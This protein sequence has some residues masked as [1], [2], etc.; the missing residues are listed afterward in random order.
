MRTIGPYQVIQNIAQN[1]VCEVLEVEHPAHAEPLVLK[2]VKMTGSADRRLEREF[3]ALRRMEHPS[4]VRVFEQGHDI[5]GHRFV[6]MERLDGISAQQWVRDFGPPGSPARTDEAV[7]IISSLASALQA[8]HQAGII[9]RDIKSDNVMILRDGTV[10]LL[11]FGAARAAGL[12]EGITR[13]GEFIGTFDYASPEQITG[14][15]LDGR[16]D[17]YALGVLFYRLLTGRRPFDGDSRYK[18]ARMHL[19]HTPPTPHHLC[20]AVPAPLSEVVM[21]MLTKSPQH[22]PTALGVLELLENPPQ[23]TTRSPEALMVWQQGL[24]AAPRRLV[25][26]LAI[27][28]TPLRTDA[29]RHMT[30]LP[31]ADTV[32]A[33]TALQEG[34]WLEQGEEGWIFCDAQAPT[35]IGSGVQ[36]ARRYLLTQRLRE[37][38]P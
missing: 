31:I 6:T 17:V 38:K 33:L 20:R 4:V 22:R 25:Q 37:F 15:A 1:E 14:D 24:A 9:H 36:R 16:A 34:G 35:L 12:C 30:D 28:R 29:L 21:R 10:K 18:L 7:R 27:A 23:S 11:D 2:R 13:D 8:L 19:Q 32:A 3:E 5:D 26:A